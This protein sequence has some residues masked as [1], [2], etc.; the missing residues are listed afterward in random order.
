MIKNFDKILTW[1]AK[2]V[3]N[4]RMVRLIGTRQL[5]VSDLTDRLRNVNISHIHK[6]LPADFIVSCIPDEQIFAR[7]DST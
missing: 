4:F 6:I 1:D 7:K 5:G 2:Y 3:P